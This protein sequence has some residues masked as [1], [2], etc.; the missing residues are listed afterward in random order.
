[1]QVK[2]LCKV[3]RTPADSIKTLS[4][5]YDSK[6]PKVHKPWV[7]QSLFSDL[8]LAALIFACFNCFS[9]PSTPTNMSPKNAQVYVI[10]Q[11]DVIKWWGVA[12][13]YS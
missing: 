9:L 2:L 13:N 3:C 1:M 8:S 10:K 11:L 4:V 5:H 6:H 12:S 7:A